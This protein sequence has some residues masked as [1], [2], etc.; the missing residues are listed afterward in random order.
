MENKKQQNK[1]PTWFLNSALDL[2]SFRE[3]RVNQD[4]LA[5]LD[6]W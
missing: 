2:C 6:L 3:N 5:N 4:M 1:K